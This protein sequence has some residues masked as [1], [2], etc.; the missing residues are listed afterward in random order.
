[1]MNHKFVFHQLDI[2]QSL[3][4]NFVW[5]IKPP[6]FHPNEKLLLPLNKFIKLA[7]KSTQ[8]MVN[9]SCQKCL[10][11]RVSPIN[12]NMFNLHIDCH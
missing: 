7:A 9:F 6:I 11:A 3:S 4:M 12:R 8:M 5:N 1:M 2:L 10:N